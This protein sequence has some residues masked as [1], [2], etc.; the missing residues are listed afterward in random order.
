[1]DGKASVDCPMRLETR[2][3]RNMVG[4]WFVRGSLLGEIWEKFGR[5]E[6][7]LRGDILDSRDRS[8][9]KESCNTDSASSVPVL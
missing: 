6:V 5:R 7:S 1:M 2:P 3:K 8:V 9:Q 4:R